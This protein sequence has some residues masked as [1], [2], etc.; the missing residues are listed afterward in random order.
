MQKLIERHDCMTKINDSITIYNAVIKNRI[1]MPPLWNAR[2]VRIDGH[3]C[4]ADFAHYV[5]RAKND[6]GLIVVE[7]SAVDKD[8]RSFVNELGIWDDKYIDG[9]RKLTDMC[10][11][12]GAKILIQLHHGGFKTHPELAS[13][14]SVSDYN[15]GNVHA[16]AMTHELIKSTIENFVKAAKRAEI[17]GFDGIELHACHGYLIDQFASPDINRRN[18][19]FGDFAAFGVSIIKKIKKVCNDDFIICVRTGINSLYQKDSINVA[20][21]YQNAGAHLLSISNSV[22][23]PPRKAPENWQFS[24]IAYLAY[25]VKQQVDIPVVAVHSIK[26]AD[27][28]NTLLENNYC[29]MVAIGRGHLIN[30]D[31]TS[32]SLQGDKVSE[33]YDCKGCYFAKSRNKCP[34]IKL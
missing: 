13:P 27:I 1:M 17:A 10:H 18:D 32:R 12:Y 23:N 31:W 14:L 33:C 8:G 30:A 24:D 11:T 6:T 5:E 7:A 16:D 4:D 3:L 9:F 15:N 20:I 29:D 28:A 19:E 25:L 2:H 34:A 22:N 26:N 21:Q